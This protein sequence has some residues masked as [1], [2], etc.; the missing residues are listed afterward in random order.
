MSRRGEVIA[1]LCAGA[2]RG[3]CTDAERRGAR[4]VQRRLLADGRDAALETVWVRPQWP[5]TVLLYTALGI[6]ASLLAVPWPRPAGAALVVI[7]ASALLEATGRGRVLSLV[8]HRRATQNVDSPPRTERPYRLVVTAALDAGRGGLVF[9]P[10]ARRAAARA[11]RVAGGLLPGPAGWLAIFLVGAIACA[12]ARAAGAHGAAIGAVQLLPTLGLVAVGAFALD[13]ATSSYAPGANEAASAVAVAL[14]LVAALDDAAPREL[15]VEL[16]L[17]GAG[18]GGALGF[19]RHLAAHGYAPERTAV[20]ELRP[21]GAGTP[22]WWTHDGPVLGLPAPGQMRRL[23]EQIAAEETGLGALPHRTRSRSAAHAARQRRLPALSIG[24]RAPD[25]TLPL[26]RTAADV[27][28]SVDDRAMAATLDFA[29]ALV[30]ALDDELAALAR[31]VLE[32]R[33]RVGIA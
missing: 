17:S 2:Q 10:G 8:L 1:Q 18:E 22:R 32:G 23:A 14:D 6:A 26:A 21:C 11:Q 9:R 7:L 15:G 3:P 29:L 30:S 31:E 20:L 12:G 25:G 4:A 19:A 28:E 16:V 33:Q 24:C 13:I 5:L 27:P